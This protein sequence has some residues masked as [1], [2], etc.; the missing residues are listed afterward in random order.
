MSTNLNN[1]VTRLR[2][3]IITIIVIVPIILV[4][5]TGS[6]SVSSIQIFPAAGTYL[7]N[8]QDI[9]SEVLLIEVEVSQGISDQ[10]YIDVWY[11]KGSVYA[12]E[13]IIVVS[14]SIQNTHKQYKE[15]AM[16]AEGYDSKGELVSYTLD[17][18]HIQGQIGIHLEN[19]E[20]G[21]FTLHLNMAKGIKSIR[22]FANNYAETPP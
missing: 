4:A 8:S 20:T 19:E 14:G 5:C 11:P 1:L 3:T 13:P 7:T 10:D 2:R 17:R 12:G 21:Q 9:S 6:G 15:I 16:Y 22:L 18:A